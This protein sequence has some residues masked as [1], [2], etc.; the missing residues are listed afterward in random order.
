MTQ[1][2]SAIATL[3]I[4]LIAMA[5]IVRIISLEDALKMIGRAS[6]LFLLTLI[7]LYILQSLFVT[8]IGPWLASS[9][10]FLKSALGWTLIAVVILG[11]LTLIWHLLSRRSE[12]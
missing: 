7:A 8:V 9:L 11:T 4:V 3:D 2:L 10:S 12:P 6:L 5:L 1:L